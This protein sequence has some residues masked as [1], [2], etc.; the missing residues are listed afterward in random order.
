MVR[1]LPW[2]LISACALLSAT[3]TAQTVTEFSQ[4]ITPNSA[5]WGITSGPDGNIWFTEAR[6]S[7]IGRFIP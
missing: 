4:G 6:A 7:K 2:A 1:L 3:G 5:P